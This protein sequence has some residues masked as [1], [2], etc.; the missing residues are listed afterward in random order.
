MGL[1]IQPQEMPERESVSTK[2]V[3][4]FFSKNQFKNHIMGCIFG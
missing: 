4:D 3:R 1:E 2:R